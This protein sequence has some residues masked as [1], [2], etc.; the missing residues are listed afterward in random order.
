MAVKAPAFEEIGNGPPAFEDIGNG[1]PAF[2]D[3]TVEPKRYETRMPGLELPDDP[4]EQNKVL[5]DVLD[6]ASRAE[7]PISDI[8]NNYKEF[9][10]KPKPPAWR[11]VA[12]GYGALP[13][14]ESGEFFADARRE[15]RSS[16]DNI[17]SSHDMADAVMSGQGVIE[18]YEKWD[19]QQE[20]AQFRAE[21]IETSGPVK[22]IILKNIATAAPMLKSLYEASPFAFGGAVVGMGIATIVG[23]LGPQ[24]GSPE[25]L[26][27][28]PGAGR[29]GA[30]AGFAIGTKLGMT[31]ST[32][33]FWYRQ[34]LGD[35][36]GN[37]PKRYRPR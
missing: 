9:K 8:E 16:L 34:G 24:A 5:R 27:T 11:N 6:M 2:E 14:T 1:P 33:E 7:M 4:A 17:Q 3:I 31:A 36:Y 26:L 25:E 13:K 19:K 30:K 15:V 28:V 10:G 37:M 35:F 12:A 22:S 29:V 23:Q 18:A 21:V 20:R 32:A